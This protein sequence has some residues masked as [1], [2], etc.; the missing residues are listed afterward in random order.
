MHNYMSLIL[1]VIGVIDVGNDLTYIQYIHVLTHYLAVRVHGVNV[2]CDII[3]DLVLSLC[4]PV[5]SISVKS[6]LTGCHF[7]WFEFQQLDLKYLYQSQP[8]HHM[9]QCKSKW[10]MVNINRCKYIYVYI[11]MYIYIYIYIWGPLC[12]KQVSQILSKMRYWCL[13]I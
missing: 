2:W 7:G 5:T 4:L 3:C 11:Y 12:Q 6:I 1:E 9:E 10:Y 13:V 8:L